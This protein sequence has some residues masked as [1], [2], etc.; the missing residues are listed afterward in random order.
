MALQIMTDRKSKGI[1]QRLSGG[2]LSSSEKSGSIFKRGIAALAQNTEAESS[3]QRARFAYKAE[4]FSEAALWCLN[5]A[6]LGHAEAQS[7]LGYCY[8]FGIGVTRDDAQAVHWYSKAAEQGDA[9]AQNA[10]GDCYASGKGVTRDDAHIVNPEAKSC[11]QRALAAYKAENFSEAVLW[12]RKA[13]DQGHALAQ[14][15]LGF[16]YEL[17]IG[18]TQDDAQAVL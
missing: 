10:L 5:A 4:N 6:D 17:G 2:V 14:R 7:A 16:C 15:N 18:V 3:F 1:L 9:E 13:A 12:C 11:F 8:E